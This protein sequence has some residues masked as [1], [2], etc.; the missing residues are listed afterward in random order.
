MTLIKP[1][2][3]DWE[4]PYILTNR[5]G[6]L[7]PEEYR[8]YEVNDFEHY[9]LKDG[10]HIH[11]AEQERWYSKHYVAYVY[12]DELKDSTRSDFDAYWEELSGEG[13]LETW[14]TRE[15]LYESNEAFISWTKILDEK[16]AS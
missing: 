13:F 3:F 4:S 12:D 9:F 1:E 5:V 15:Y 10:Q 2:G 11:F 6:I 7:T 14:M 8:K 16:M